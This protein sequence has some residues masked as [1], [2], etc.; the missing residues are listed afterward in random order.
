MIR[1]VHKLGLLWPPPDTALRR[2]W[3]RA[4][5]WAPVAANTWDDFRWLGA[6]EEAV[7]RHQRKRQRQ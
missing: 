1:L 6:A 7:A 4:G 5:T 3:A 2:P